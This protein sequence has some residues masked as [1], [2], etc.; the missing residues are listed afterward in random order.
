MASQPDKVWLD[1]SRTY[2]L[3]GENITITPMDLLVKA[4]RMQRDG[5][6]SQQILRELDIVGLAS[7]FQLER[8]IKNYG[9]PELERR[10]ASGQEQAETVILVD[11]YLAP[12]SSKEKDED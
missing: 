11:R 8:A 5:M 4:A 10:I 2:A 7:S 1:Q 3:D 12:L 9:A 6:S